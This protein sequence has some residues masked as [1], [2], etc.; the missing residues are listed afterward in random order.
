MMCSEPGDACW[1]LVEYKIID[2]ASGGGYLGV[3][4]L[5]LFEAVSFSVFSEIILSFAEYLV[6]RR[7]PQKALSASDVAI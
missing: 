7:V 1:G 5:T 2:V 6:S 3:F 4:S